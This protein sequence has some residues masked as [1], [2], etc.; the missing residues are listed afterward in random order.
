MD[1]NRKS[2]NDTVESNIKINK[3]LEDGKVHAPISG[4]E[5]EMANIEL[6]EQFSS[7]SEQSDIRTS[8][9]SIV[10]PQ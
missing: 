7:D 9:T 8:P 6:Q 2:V 4:T 5:T 10:T 3:Q 1:N